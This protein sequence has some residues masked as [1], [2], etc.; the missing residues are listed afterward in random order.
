MGSNPKDVIKDDNLAPKIVLKSLETASRLLSLVGKPIYVFILYILNTT[1]RLV[2]GKV[3]R[4]H[5]KFPKRGLKKRGIIFSSKSLKRKLLLSYYKKR[6]E[7]I[8][9]KLPR[10]KSPRYSPPSDS[11]SLFTPPKKPEFE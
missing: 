1:G 9:S 8:I 3:S 7:S 6:F 11:T 4:L 10:T 2:E 5:F